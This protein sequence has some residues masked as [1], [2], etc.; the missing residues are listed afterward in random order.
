MPSPPLLDFEALLAPIPGDNPAGDG[1]PFAMRE[2]IDEARKEINPEDYDADDPTRPAEPK[3]ADWPTIERVTK[4]ALTENCKD[5]LVAARLTEALAKSSGFAGLRDGLHLMRRMVGD[6]WDR[7]TPSIEDGDLEMRAGPFNWLDEADRGARFP[8]TVRQVPLIADGEGHFSWF[9]W[10]QIQE[11]KGTVTQQEFERALQIMPREQLQATTEDI[12]GAAEELR[13][14]V[15]DL[16]GKLGEFAPGMTGLGGALN[17]CRNLAR[18]LLERRG[19]PPQEEG[20]G[21]AADGESGGN[22]QGG[23]AMGRAAVTRDDV[24][25]RLSELAATLERLEPHSPI[26]WL[27]NRAVELG[28]MPFPLLMRALIRDSNVLSELNREFGI[29]EPEQN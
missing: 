12:E 10:R 11:G 26:P 27:I 13:T 20:E 16:G 15:D 21:G 23:G 2:K 9:D 25:R 22:G 3:Y 17:D 5:L 18:L 19:G 6:C 7:I 29:K 8:V 14:L 24:Y 28:A 4:Q 1:L